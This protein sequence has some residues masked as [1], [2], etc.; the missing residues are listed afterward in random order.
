MDDD[1]AACAAA[2]MVNLVGVD[3]LAGADISP[4]EFADADSLSE[5]AVETPVDATARLSEALGECDLAVLIAAEMAEG[6]MAEAGWELPP[7]VTACLEVKLSDQ[8]VADAAATFFVDG[9][10]EDLR[11]AIGQALVACPEALTAILLAQSPAE[12]APETEAC[13]LDFVGANPELTAAFFEQDAAAAQKIG[14][15][16]AGACPAFGSG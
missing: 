11:T 1:T 13:V 8:A 5:L 14:T 9:S 3:A 7:E 2:A 4:E 16:L 6:I 15:G 12:E 10:P